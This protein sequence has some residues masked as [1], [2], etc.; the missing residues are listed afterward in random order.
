[1]LNAAQL[2]KFS[3]GLSTEDFISVF[4]V[5]RNE[6]KGFLKHAN[7]RA[8]HKLSFSHEF[9]EVIFEEDLRVGLI[10]GDKWIGLDLF[11]IFL[12]HYYTIREHICDVF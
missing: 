11:R 9:E 4:G 3:V 1:M 10:A 5:H 2:A 12:L 8:R 7:G 6:R